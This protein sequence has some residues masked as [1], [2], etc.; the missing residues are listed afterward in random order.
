MAP[1]V[2]GLNSD[3]F[4]FPVGHLKEHVYS[5]PTRT[6]EDLVARLQA[7]VTRVNVNMLSCARQN[8]VQ[9]ASVSLEID[10]FCFDH[11]L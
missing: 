5:V 6:V 10:G 2:A 9:R 8:A 3:G 11:Q 7:A 1:S 4:F